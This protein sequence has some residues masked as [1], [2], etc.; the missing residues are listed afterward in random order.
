MAS[1]TRRYVAPE[2]AKFAPRLTLTQRVFK[3][4][5]TTFGAS[6]HFMFHAAHQ[7]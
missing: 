5:C 7:S 6:Q 2:G 1:A 4:R 3:L